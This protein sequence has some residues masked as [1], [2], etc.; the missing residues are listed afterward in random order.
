MMSRQHLSQPWQ[1]LFGK[2]LAEGIL[3]TLLAMLLSLLCHPADAAELANVAPPRAGN[4]A[5]SGQVFQDCH[6]AH[7]LEMVVIPAGSFMMGSN[8]GQDNEKPI[9]R[10]TLKAFAL[11]KYAVTKGQFAV[12]VQA[13]AYR[14]EAE[15]GDG[16]YGWRGSEFKKSTMYSRRNAGFEQGDDHPVVCVSWNDAK[17]YTQWLNQSTGRT[18]RL[19]S[20]AEREYAARAGTTSQY[21]WGDTASHEHANYG[22]DTC[23]SGLAQGKDQWEYTAPVGQF[24]PNAFGLHDLHG[25]VWEWVQDGYHDS[26]IGAPTD[27]SAWQRRAE[28][29]YRVLRGGSWDYV[30][31]GMRSAFRDWLTP[32]N[33]AG[34]LG[35]RVARSV[36]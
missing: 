26:Y 28:Q 22:T 27:G 4:A 30:P 23:C 17:A 2:L 10:V 35:F 11:G 21:M 32:T 29:Q 5:Q 8:V 13:T 24:P 6:E 1:L 14:T 7:C 3:F 18:Y 15:L 36:P 16:C 33:R 12:F 31:D 25:N 9:H 20:E 34:N 19:P